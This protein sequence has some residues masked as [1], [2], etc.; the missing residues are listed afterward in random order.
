MRPVPGT[1]SAGRA[2]P[3]G[4]VRLGLC[5][6]VAVVAAILA[7]PGVAAAQAS[8]VLVARVDGPITPVVAQYLIDGVRQAEEHGHRALLVEMDTPGGLDTSMREIIQAFLAAE[9]PVIVYV[10][11]AGGRAASAGALITFSAHLAVMAPGT[12]I[13]AATPVNAE[14]GETATDKV[15]NDAAAFA[16]SVAAQRGRNAEFAVATVREGRSVTAEEAQ[17]LG[18]VDLIAAD[19]AAMLAAVD[20][21]KVT[22]PGDRQVSLETA[23]ARTVDHDM[24]LLR[25][26][27]AVIADP[28]LAFLFLSIGTLAVIYELATP[29]MGLGGVTGAI[30]L[31]LGF[32]ALSV[33]PVTVAGLALLVLAAALFAAEVVTPGIGVFATGGTIALVVSGLFLFDDAAVR[34]NPAVLLPT[35]AVVGGGSLLAGRLAWRTRKTPPATGPQ[36]LIGATTTVTAAAGHTGR[37]RLD[38]AWWT[39]HSPNTTLRDG[40]TVHVRDVRDLTLTVEPVTTTGTAPEPGADA[41]E[42]PH[43]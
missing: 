27:L 43:A 28:N 37:V 24:G 18:A 15:I 10:S 39:V 7:A 19:R 34:V 33:L 14:T 6:V 36:T 11:P 26:L 40:Q 32:F 4:A 42:D 5:A 20:A 2:C 29:G 12:T 38:G 9:V 13:G 35:A 31:V 41:M 16:E 1:P 30:L 25:R 17:R 23:D 3:A 22:L 21:R 8:T